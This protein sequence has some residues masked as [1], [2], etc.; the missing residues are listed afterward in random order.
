MMLFDTCKSNFSR[1]MSLLIFEDIVVSANESP[2]FYI[3][4]KY[5][6]SYKMRSWIYKMNKKLI[7][8]LDK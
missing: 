6:I 2:S 3:L 5:S 7:A 1:R 8:A 4:F